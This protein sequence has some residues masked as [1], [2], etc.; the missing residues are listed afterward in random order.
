MVQNVL[1]HVH[2]APEEAFEQGRVMDWKKYTS[3][4]QKN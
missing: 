1:L 3:N 4:K 2:M